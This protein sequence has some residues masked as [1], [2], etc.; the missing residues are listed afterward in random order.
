[1]SIHAAMGI[2]A[3]KDIDRAMGMDLAQVVAMA[4][5][6]SARKCTTAQIPSQITPVIQ[7]REN[8]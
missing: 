7:P 4:K 8:Q 1:M 3:I 5:A 6:R 2:H